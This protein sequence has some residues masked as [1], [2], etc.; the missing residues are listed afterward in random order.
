M[1][2]NL[3][4]AQK[5]A[6]YRINSKWQLESLLTHY[7]SRAT[8]KALVN[9]GFIEREARPDHK[10]GDFVFWNA[11]YRLKDTKPVTG[12]VG[13]IPCAECGCD[14]YQKHNPWCSVVKVQV[15]G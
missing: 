3:S 5:D 4:H 2:A 9:K 10:V 11:Y 6:L 15:V 12:G 13:G 1:S 7:M 14:R 8:L